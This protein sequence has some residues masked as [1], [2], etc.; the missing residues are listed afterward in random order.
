MT[1]PAAGAERGRA[2][3]LLQPVPGPASADAAL[4]RLIFAQLPAG[5]TVITTVSARGEPCGMTAS[6]VCSLSL[7]PL[8]LLAC[9]KSTSATLARLLA[10]GQFAVSILRREHAGLSARFAASRA[11]K[12]AGVRYHDAGGAPVLDEALAWLSCRVHATYPGGDHTIVVGAVTEM[13]RGEGEPLVWHASR[14]RA[15]DSAPG[16]RPAGAPG[17]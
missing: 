3:A 16:A 6:A 12:F 17:A 8:L 13:D 2:T 10:H 11:D 5:V 1:M 15:L 7:E 4:F 14:Y 9:V